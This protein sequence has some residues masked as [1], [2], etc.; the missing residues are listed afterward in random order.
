MPVPTGPTTLNDAAIE[1]VEDGYYHLQQVDVEGLFTLVSG[2]VSVEL[3]SLVAQLVTLGVV[4]VVVFV[5]A[6]R[7][8]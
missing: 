2:L 7:R 3:F 5:V 6:L 4:L 1:V 8:L